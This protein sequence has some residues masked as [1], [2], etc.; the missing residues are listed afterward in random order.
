VEVC[1]GEV[2]VAL[3]EPYLKRQGIVLKFDYGGRGNVC[4][5][6]YAPRTSTTTTQMENNKEG[7]E[8][9]AEA[10]E[11]EEEETPVAVVEVSDG[12]ILVHA[13]PPLKQIC[14]SQSEQTRYRDSWT[15]LLNRTKETRAFTRP[16]TVIVQ[17]FIISLQECETVMYY[18]FDQQDK[19][20]AL[21]QMQF[22]ATG[23]MI[24]FPV[25]KEG[26]EVTPCCLIKKMNKVWKEKVVDKPNFKEEVGYMITNP[27]WGIYKQP[28]L[29][30][31]V[32]CY[33]NKL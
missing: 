14:P 11:S 18:S 6:R 3:R 24:P 26:G 5:V 32:N 12:P 2:P 30:F 16:Q 27:P 33:T 15:S 17:P 20:I 13:L 1:K 28:F 21:A 9:E 4:W 29:P 31:R 23:E 22:R 10:V 8:E 25:D 7:S 19:L